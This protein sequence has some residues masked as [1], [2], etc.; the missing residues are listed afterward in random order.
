M[1]GKEIRQALD[2][3]QIPY[4][5]NLPEDLL[6]YYSTLTEWNA[7]MDLTAAD[8]EDE[9]LDK[10]FIDSLTVLKTGIIRPKSVLVD[11]GTGAGFPGLAVAMARKDL[12]V[13]LIDAQQ[14]RL[15]FLQAVIDRV[16]CENVTLVHA[17]AEDAAHRA[18]LR[19]SFDYA[20]ARAL[21]PLNVLSEYL[22][23]FVKPGGYALCWKGPALE[24]EA[25]EGERAIALLGGQAEKAIGC[26]V[27][28]RDWDH[29]ILAVRK[30]RNTPRKYPR[31]AGTP[32]A[33]PLGS[34]E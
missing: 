22:L 26:P 11:V 13:T 14:K 2:L 3:N 12:S 6:I 1:T 20:T 27:A 10:H 9:I 30:I 4:R 16:K 28:G 8:E 18:G 34:A 19:E 5:E 32:K 23:P 31:K 24:K 21:A 29:R 33:S 17:R 7:K 15:N 25:E